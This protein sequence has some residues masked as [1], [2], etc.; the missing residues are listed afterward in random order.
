MARLFRRK[1][2]LSALTELNLTPLMDL[3]FALLIIFMVSTPL[4]EQTIPLSLPTESHCEPLPS[5]EAA[6][7][8]ISIDP[9]G[10]YFWGEESVTLKALNDRLAVCASA[11]NP[12]VLH[13]RADAQL[14]YQKVV[15]LLDLIK[16]HHLIKISLDTQPR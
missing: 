2:P 7:K 4:L 8:V 11:K 6:Y 16:Q 5:E 13:I 12:P 1:Q 15:D 10:N 14:A 9:A 3:A